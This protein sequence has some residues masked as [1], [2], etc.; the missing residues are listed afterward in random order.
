MIVD[1]YAPIKARL[2][3]VADLRSQLLKGRCPRRANVGTLCDVGSV[4]AATFANNMC[5][6]VISIQI[7]T[8]YME[9]RPLRVTVL[10]NITI[11]IIL[12]R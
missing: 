4:S 1:A 7:N 10:T 5:Y 3:Y 2:L 11:I 8:H 9:P 6:I 12:Y